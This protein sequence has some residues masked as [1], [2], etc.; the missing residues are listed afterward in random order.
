M[1]VDISEI[2]DA[3]LDQ[4]FS[5]TEGHFLDLKAKE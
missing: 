4:I 2:T 3:Q 5:F 1:P